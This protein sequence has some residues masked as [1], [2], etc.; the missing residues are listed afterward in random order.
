MTRN[1]KMVQYVLV[2]QKR[3]DEIGN[4]DLAIKCRD[5]KYTHNDEWVINTLRELFPQYS[6]MISA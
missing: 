2:I 5:K 6:G 4:Y 1:Q 3:A